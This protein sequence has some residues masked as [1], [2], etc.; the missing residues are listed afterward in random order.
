MRHAF[1][2]E[3]PF[4]IKCIQCMQLALYQYY[5]IILLNISA[6]Q[7]RVVQCGVGPRNSGGGA[8]LSFTGRTHL[9]SVHYA[10]RSM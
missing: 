7:K 5:H 4:I 3:W 8:I 6:I 10:V 9:S 1:R 2:C